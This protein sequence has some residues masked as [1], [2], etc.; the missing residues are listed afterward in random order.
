MMF[1]SSTKTAARYLSISTYV[2]SP[3]FRVYFKYCGIHHKQMQCILFLSVKTSKLPCD[4]IQAHY[5]Y[6]LVAKTYRSTAYRRLHVRAP[7]FG[8]SLASVLL[9]VFDD[10]TS[11][12]EF[13]LWTVYP[14]TAFRSTAWPY[15]TNIVVGAS[16][17]YNTVVYTVLFRHVYTRAQAY[18]ITDLLRPNTW[19][20]TY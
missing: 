9:F 17:S 5:T 13:A 12:A 15:F 16:K 7:R 2:H 14:A 19:L 11:D 6:I 10:Y 18:E 4:S 8:D 3:F 1:L 20:I